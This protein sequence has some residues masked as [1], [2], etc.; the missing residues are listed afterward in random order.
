MLVMSIRLSNS[1][2]RPNSPHNNR[3]LGLQS[4]STGRTCK[5]RCCTNNFTQPWPPT[6]YPT[7]THLLSEPQ[8][9][10]KSPIP[11]LTHHTIYPASPLA[12]L[13]TRIRRKP[14][15][16]HLHWKKNDVY[17][18]TQV[19]RRKS[20]F[21]NTLVSR[22]RPFY[23]LNHLPP[24]TNYLPA[25]HPAPCC[26]PNSSFFALS[27]STQRSSFFCLSLLNGFWGDGWVS[28]VWG[29]GW[30]MA[31]GGWEGLLRREDESRSAFSKPRLL[32]LSS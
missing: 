21:E 19:R 3:K 31:E 20:I 16:Q 23:K 8:H 5:K 24:Q 28:E 15:L 30:P 27:L 2:T 10:P 13:N 17:N 7:V 26:K 22:Q 32:V 9:H 6:I 1:A 12:A 25:I 4:G 11:N 18:S 14:S 29:W